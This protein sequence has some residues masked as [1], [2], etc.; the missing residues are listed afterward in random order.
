MT[1]GIQPDEQREIERRG[2]YHPPDGAPSAPSDAELD[3]DEHFP[4]A[5]RSY[6]L[7]SGRRALTMSCYAGRDYSG[8]WGNFFAHTLVLESPGSAPPHW[9]VDYAEWSG[10]VRRLDSA[11]GGEDAPKPLPPVDLAAVEPAESYRLE[12][13]QA[14]VR[15]RSDR[16]ARLVEMARALLVPREDRRSL[17]IRADPL[18]GMFWIAALVKLLP[19]ALAWDLSLSTYQYQ[20]RGVA[21]VNVTVVGTEFSF[22]EAERRYRFSMFEPEAG[23]H[24]TARREGGQGYPELATGWL[25][26]RP[27]TL[28]GF[29]EY[30]DRYDGVALEAGPLRGAAHL[31]VAG[32]AT[33][34]KEGLELGAALAFAARHVAITGQLEALE[35]LGDGI[36]TAPLPEVDAEV[37]PVL[38]F[39]AE[40]AAR[41]GQPR[42]RR[43]AWRVWE[44]WLA[45]TLERPGADLT[46]L[47]RARRG[48]FETLEDWRDWLAERWLETVGGYLE[49]TDPTILRWTLDAAGTVDRQAPWERPEARRLIANLL[50]R[51]DPESATETLL[52]VADD[53][54]ALAALVRLAA[55]THGPEVVGRVLARRPLEDRT[56]ARARRDLEQTG[57]GAAILWAEWQARSSVT[58]DPRTELERYRRDVLAVLPVFAAAYGDALHEDVFDR[59]SGDPRREQAVAWLLDRP[60]FDRFPRALRVR[61]VTAAQAALPLVGGGGDADQ[62]GVRLQEAVGELGE[63]LRPDRP[64]LRQA[65]EGVGK[66]AGRRELREIRAALGAID[67]PAY[68]EFLEL[69]LVPSLNHVD[70]AVEHAEQL[71]AVCVPGLEHQFFEGF[72]AWLRQRPGS[73]PLPALRAA[74]EAA[75]GPKLGAT[76]PGG[77]L[78][79]TRADLLDAL[80]ELRDAELEDLSEQLSASAVPRSVWEQIARQVAER[81]DSALHR[82]WRRIK[83][84]VR[85]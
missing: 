39:L 5:F 14:F 31:F 32:E 13:L 42:H 4:R 16:P 73:V 6:R 17:V 84:L 66:P 82:G 9:P 10:W 67:G 18:D 43:A 36:E 60:R 1:P 40:G 3:L 83:R 81:R 11:A 37:E 57:E 23:A 12:E 15:E 27:E 38:V 21:D 65:I 30:L 24:P 28:L 34:P 64:R 61:L 44:R 63:P 50:R 70:R 80:A 41:T 74:L 56:L 33:L 85:D 46:A 8:R 52:S 48:L 45:R 26:E 69:F 75:L 20:L 55:A 58:S 77:L 79:A 72:R 62:L 2:I 53:G 35:R 54:V 78:E 59:L 19:P 7:A 76:L 68:L 22:D 25:V 51:G 71:R 49:S 29:F 47:D